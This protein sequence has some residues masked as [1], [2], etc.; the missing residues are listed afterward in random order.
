MLLSVSAR[1][2]H[3]D[4]DMSSD[5][6]LSEAAAQAKLRIRAGHIEQLRTFPL[7]SPEPVTQEEHTEKR[8]IYKQWLLKCSRESNL[9]IQQ[10]I[11]QRRFTSYSG[12]VCI[13]DHLGLQR[14]LAGE[15]PLWLNRHR[16]D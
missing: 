14:S 2:R 13:D 16:A 10:A 1:S 5:S 15:L 4:T 8:S 11:S 9:Q 6:V 12:L 3:V 7:P